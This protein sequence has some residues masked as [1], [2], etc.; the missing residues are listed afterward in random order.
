MPG[1]ADLSGPWLGSAEAGEAA[2]RAAVEIDR[3]EHRRHALPARVLVVLL[4][5]IGL[6]HLLLFHRRREAAEY[7]WYGLAAIDYAAVAFAVELITDFVDS[8]SLRRRLIG[9]TLHLGAA[10]TIQFLWPFLGRRIGRSLHLYQL[11]H[12]VLAAAILVT[13][14]L[15]WVLHSIEV[16][17]IWSL[18]M[19]LGMAH[20]LVGEA[21][22]GIA[23]ARMILAGG[24]VFA[25]AALV[26]VVVQAAGRG[27]SFPVPI[28]AFALFSIAMAAALSIRFGRI[29]NELDELRLHLEQVVDEQT[30]ELSQANR[31]LR[32]ENAE[33]QLAEE[34]MRMLERAVEQSIDGIAVTDMTGS[35]LFLNEAWARMHGYQAPEVLGY[36]LSLF[37]TPEQM[38]AQ[39]YPLLARVREKGAGDGEVGHRKRDGSTFPAWV[40]ATLLQD[41]DKGPV[42]IVNIVRDITRRRQAQRERLQLEDKARQAE[43]LQS[44]AGLAGGI[45]HDYNNLLTGV[46][47]HA[48]GALEVVPQGSVIGG[49]IEQIRIAA[50]KA[51]DL[52]G[53]LVAFAG[54]ER[55][56]LSTR[57]LNELLR[58]LGEELQREISE[59]IVLQFQ[60]K[61]ALP[62][63]EIDPK[64]IRRVV[65]QL[66][67]NAVEAIDDSEGV[68]TL[69]TSKVDVDAAY[70][71]DAV[72]NEDPRPGQYVFFEVSDSGCGI[73]EE[74]RAQ[75]FQPFFSTRAPG[76]G[77]G[78]ASVLGIV[79]SHRGA[80][81]VYS[82]P[83]KGTT[84]EVL[85]PAALGKVEVSP[86]ENIEG[87]TGSGALLVID[88]EEIVREVSKDILEGVDFEVLTARDGPEALRR[89]AERGAEIRA[90]LLDMTMPEMDGEET[91]RE[92]RKLDSE[93]RIILMSG[94]AQPRVVRRLT[95]EGLAGS[96]HKP[97]RPDELVR[98]V[99]QVLE[100]WEGSPL[101]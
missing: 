30:Q 15:T 4:T 33:R 25:G 92:I 73:A 28:F 80:L 35:T 84:V 44:L 41:P 31:Q 72:P 42:G 85:F 50:E 11:S 9:V 52:T 86:A 56:V 96:L 68:I 3:P 95:E 47:G 36:D 101:R 81:K 90:V 64:L 91:F 38:Q 10:L 57:H 69:R 67:T 37:H 65:L 88:D 49:K 89:V 19:F 87:W 59:R 75:M 66:V 20:L 54:E 82:Q 43:K 51:A 40:S 76:R 23:E 77:L 45:A 62:P 14:S 22:R 97:F 46:L 99:R 78:L 48:S 8:Q 53:Q 55:I 16:R 21:R 74:T 34:S 17:W 7:L 24:L 1:S 63:V 27:T 79:R 12:A 83:G 94:T 61:S 98:K 5:A 93:A 39:M 6:Y 2:W 71:A 58:G 32:S 60:L 29:H 18:P 26:E 13:P 70:F 100:V